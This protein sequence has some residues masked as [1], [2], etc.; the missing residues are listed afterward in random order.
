MKDTYYFSHDYNTRTDSKI[1]KLIRVHKM[2]GYGIFWAIIEDLYNNANAMQTDYD[3]IAFDLHSDSKTIKSIINDFDLFVIEGDIFGSISVERRLSERNDKSE[4][5][6]QSAFKRWEQSESNAIAM[7]SHSEGNAIK[8]KKGKEKK[9]KEKKRKESG[10][11]L[12]F[13]FDSN[14]FKSVWASWK[15]YKRAQHKFT[16]KSEL[17]EQAALKS[18]GSLSNNDEDTA[19]AIIEQ[20]IAQGWKGLFELKNQTN[21]GQGQNTGNNRRSNSRIT[22]SDRA[23]LAADLLSS[24][25]QGSD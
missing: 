3:G 15:E 1:K 19:I 6:R 13:P 11:I 9:G 23:K 16:F 8:E 22:D 24:F 14:N 25:N 17:T 2:T 20:S 21:N 10:E 5:A 12:I 7:Q 18:L 4:K